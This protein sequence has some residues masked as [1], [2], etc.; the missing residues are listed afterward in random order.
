M[1]NEIAS[2][3]SKRYEKWKISQKESSE[4]EE[5]EEFKIKRVKLWWK[6]WAFCTTLLANSTF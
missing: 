4:E 2:E 1:I 3:I 6:I 5:E